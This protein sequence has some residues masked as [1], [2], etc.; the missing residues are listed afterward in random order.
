MQRV[1]IASDMGVDYFS[2]FGNAILR[3]C[4]IRNVAAGFGEK[5]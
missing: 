5:K 4:L 3:L 1:R 2:C